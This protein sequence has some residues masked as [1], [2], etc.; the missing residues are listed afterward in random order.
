[1]CSF[2]FTDSQRHSHSYMHRAVLTRECILFDLLFLTNVTFIRCHLINLNAE[3]FYFIKNICAFIP[4]YEFMFIV[5][6]L[7]ISLTEVQSHLPHLQYHVK[8]Y[9]GTDWVT[10]LFHV[11]QILPFSISVN[12]SFLSFPFTLILASVSYIWS[13]ICF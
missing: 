4:L 1:M 10:L 6:R 2:L 12:N 13:Y 7:C 5:W 9:R 11:S 3:L 8:M